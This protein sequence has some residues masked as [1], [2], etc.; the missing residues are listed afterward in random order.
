MNERLADVINLGDRV[1]DT[2]TGIKGIVIGK[3]DWLYGCRRIV[4]QPEEAKDGKPAE[5]FSVDEP[6]VVLVKA[7]VIAHAVP[8][9]DDHVA[10]ARRAHGPRE[11]AARRSDVRR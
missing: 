4:I 2:I 1:K 9:G 7:G 5:S 8:A 3:T 11:D 10:P 6:Q